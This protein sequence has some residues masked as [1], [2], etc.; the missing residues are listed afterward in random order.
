MSSFQYNSSK[1]RGKTRNNNCIICLKSFKRI[2]KEEEGSYLQIYYRFSH[3]IKRYLQ[4]DTER[5][6]SCDQFLKGLGSENG[7]VKGFCNVCLKTVDQV[8]DLYHELCAVRVRLGSKLGELGELFQTGISNNFDDDNQD[9]DSEAV[10]GGGDGR[11]LIASKCLQKFKEAGPQVAINPVTSGHDTNTVQ[12]DPSSIVK[13]EMEVASEPSDEE[14]S[15]EWDAGDDFQSDDSWEPKHDGRNGFEIKKENE[16]LQVVDD[17][18]KELTRN[19]SSKVTK[20]RVSSK[21]KAKKRDLIRKPRRKKINKKEMRSVSAPKRK[22]IMILESDDEEADDETFSCS[23]CTEVFTSI[24]HLKNHLDDLESKKEDKP[25]QCCFCWQ[26]FALDE[27]HELHLK[28]KHTNSSFPCHESTCRLSFLKLEELNDHLLSHSTSPSE[29]LHFCSKCNWGFLSAPLLTL[30]E[31]AHTPKTKSIYTC[32][33]CDKTFAK[34]V[35]YQDH[36][37]S[38]HGDKV[39]FHRCSNCDS[40]FPSTHHLK[41]HMITHDET[42]VSSVDDADVDKDN[43]LRCPQCQKVFQDESRLRLHLWYHT[44][45]SCCGKKFRKFEHYS[46]H[47]KQIHNE[48]KVINCHICQAPLRSNSSLHKHL[49]IMHGSQMKDHLC[50]FCGKGFRHKHYLSDHIT[51]SHPEEVPK[52]GK[53]S[54]PHCAQRFHLNFKLRRHLPECDKNPDKKPA[55]PEPPVIKQQICSGRVNTCATCGRVIKNGT[56]GMR[57]HLRTHIPME[58][59]QKYKCRICAA[60]LSSNPSLWN[61]LRGFHQVKDSLCPDCGALYFT[62]DG[63]RHRC[64]DQKTNTH[65]VKYLNDKAAA[66]ARETRVSTTREG[67][68]YRLEV[69]P[70]NEEHQE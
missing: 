64:P 59:R 25:N 3:V 11:Q 57:R 35:G 40:S 22:K 56:V 28:M 48:D 1:R 69:L 32:S 63:G 17:K 50:S 37:N 61:H 27:S 34:I 47:M 66:E 13:V 33:K 68:S 43:P 29:N 26:S 62:T 60:E 36:Y 5:D 20:N 2:G 15:M 9:G 10:V 8:C 41:K 4:I 30:H 38:K 70:G 49:R 52:E 23:H 21:R 53:H 44:S 51:R 39:N 65:V 14:L 18:S 7:L 19:R 46:R 42:K 58:Q 6:A 24:Y 55:D 67:R 54:C 16:V 31:L 12:H 45:R